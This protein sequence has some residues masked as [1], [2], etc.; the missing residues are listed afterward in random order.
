MRIRTFA[1][2]NARAAIE[3]VRAEMGPHA[4]IIAL[5]ETAN[6]R[7]VIVRAAADEPALLPPEPVATDQPLE[8][9]LERLLGARLLSWSLTRTPQ[10]A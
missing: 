5:D 3:L 4:I 6:G 9:R 10:R 8:Q 1:A 7:G 2:D